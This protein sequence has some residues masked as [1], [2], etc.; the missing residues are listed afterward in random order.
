METLAP[1]PEDRVIFLG[2]LINKGPDSVGVV[3]YVY[4][5]G[6]E[7]VLGNNDLFY[8][9]GYE[10]SP[11]YQEYHSRLSPEIHNWLVSLP[12]YIE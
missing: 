6:Y 4:E 12:S 10:T 7:C 5:H 2:D 8:I 11:K 3:R 1:T 9:K